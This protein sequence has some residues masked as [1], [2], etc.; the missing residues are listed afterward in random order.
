M[1]VK[2]SAAGSLCM[3]RSSSETVPGMIPSSA[4]KEL[5]QDS[6]EF[7]E[8]SPSYVLHGL[9]EGHCSIC[10]SNKA[11]SLRGR[12]LAVHIKEN[13]RAYFRAYIGTD[14]VNV[15]ERI[16]KT[17]IDEMKHTDKNL[18]V[19]AFTYY[20]DKQTSTIYSAS[21]GKIQ[22]VIVRIIDGIR[23]G[24]PITSGTKLLS[25]D[26]V[27]TR[28]IAAWE[29]EADNQ[30]LFRA[31]ENP[32]AVGDDLYKNII[33]YPQ[34]YHITARSN[35][36]KLIYHLFRTDR[37]NEAEEV[38]ALMEKN[39]TEDFNSMEKDAIST[40]DKQEVAEYRDILASWVIGL[41][42]VLINFDFYLPERPLN[43][44]GEVIA[45]AG[46][47]TARGAIATAYRIIHA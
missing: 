45:L 10:D 8:D 21:T 25:G 31:L 5:A 24:F 33:K 36:E 32:R 39:W 44:L 26:V 3:I 30:A 7:T 41:K 2:A 27:V 29:K 43:R 16:F 13:F 18:E 19:A 17:S 37:K 11:C 42:N 9:F 15:L 47:H 4:Y 12:V 46:K 34:S 35:V 28:T 14:N 1:A 23:Q 22:G 20:I 38:L 6:T 40:V